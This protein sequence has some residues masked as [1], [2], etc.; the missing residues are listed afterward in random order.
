MM[1]R[2]LKKEFT[3]SSLKGFALMELIVGIIIASIASLAILYG[4][5]YVQYSSHAVRIK[6]RAYEELKSYT[7]LW[8]GKIAANDISEGGILSEEKPVCLDLIEE[9]DGSCDNNAILY[10]N[11]NLI[12][13][14]LSH[15]KRNGL[16]TRIVWE[17]RSGDQKEINFYIEQ[18]VF[19]K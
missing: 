1:Q 13:T 10:S 16:K 11:L 6:E 2:N 4:V 5:L 7:E 19:Q 15:A 3:K 14:G 18:L 8:K 9:A 17:T 12:D